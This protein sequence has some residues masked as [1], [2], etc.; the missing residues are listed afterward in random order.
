MSYIPPSNGIKVSSAASKDLEKTPKGSLAGR[1]AICLPAAANYQSQWEKLGITWVEPVDKNP[2]LAKALL[3]EGWESRH[4][5][6]GFSDHLHITLL[7][8]DH[9]PR[10]NMF[11]KTAFYDLFASAR[12]LTKEEGELQLQQEIEK[13][14]IEKKQNKEAEIAKDFIISKR[15]EAWSEECPFGVFFV[16]DM[17]EFVMGGYVN[18]AKR[19]S[20]H[21]FFPT[22]EIANKAKKLLERN[23]GYGDSVFTQKVDNSNL[24]LVKQGGYKVVNGFIDKLWWNTRSWED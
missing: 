6:S 1:K 8:S 13:A 18:E 23:S 21:G 10:V 20:C 14:N 3:P 22:E 9:I 17:S 11:I 4:N 5:P 2:L 24:H 16:K 15:S 19:R 12:F 7:D